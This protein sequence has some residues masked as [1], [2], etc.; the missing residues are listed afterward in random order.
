MY[1]Y[2]YI[3]IYPLRKDNTPMKFFTLATIRVLSTIYV[4]NFI[5]KQTVLKKYTTKQ[6][7]NIP[8]PK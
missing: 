6:V 8:N 2:I 5:R 4:Q 3:Y 1:I 7:K